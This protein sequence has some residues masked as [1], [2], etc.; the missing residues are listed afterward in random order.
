[1]KTFL[2]KDK[3]VKLISSVTVFL[4][5]LG[6]CN[7]NDE[8]ETLTPFDEEFFLGFGRTEH[9]IEGIDINFFSVVGDSR[10]PTS[11]ECISEGQ[12][13]LFFDFIKDGTSLERF[14][15]SMGFNPLE[16]DRQPKIEVQGYL[17]EM[18]QVNPYPQSTVPMGEEVYEAV[19]KM[20][21]L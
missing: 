5:I 3:L 12:V 19:L 21:K 9:L 7:S 4:L 6:A 15:L 2:K 14:T 10:C 8:V 13:T 1:M 11:V 16:P 17:I 20:S 18:I